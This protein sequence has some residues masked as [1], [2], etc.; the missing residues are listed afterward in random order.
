MA[1]E[2]KLK[3]GTL[4]S[5]GVSGSFS[6][7]DA[8]TNWTNGA[9]I[10]NLITLA[11][12]ADDAAR[13]SDKVDLGATYASR[14]SVYAS[15]DFT[16]ETPVSGDQIHLYW[17]PSTSGTQANGNIFGNSGADA[18]AP[19]GA[20]G[21]VTIDEFVQMCVYIGSMRVTDDAAVQAGY[22]GTFTPPS[23]YGQLIVY[24]KAGDAF[25]ADDVEN[26]VT[27]VPM[28]DEVQ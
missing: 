13:Q 18:A 6:P 1:N 27:L 16:G 17:A 19:G 28:I 10:T 7:A 5:F 8:A 20:L 9:G 11:S 21:S 4:I 25:E 24:N 26:H 14:Y 12:L 3:Q 22:I 2:V 15:F 23:R